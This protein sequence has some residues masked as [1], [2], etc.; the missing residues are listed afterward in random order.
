MYEEIKTRRSF[1][2]ISHPDAGKTTIT[3]KLLYNGGVIQ[4]AGE[5]KARKS[6]RH[7]TS[8]W[9]ELEKQRGISVTTSVMQIPYREHFINLLDTPGHADFSEDTYRTLS[10]VDSALMVIDAAK[11]VEARTIKLMEVCRLRNTPIIT[12]I[13]KLDR[14]CLDGMTLLSEIESVLKI[15]CAPI[16]WPI[17][18][19]KHF[20]GSYNLVDNSV[21]LYNKGKPSIKVSSLDSPE[22]AIIDDQ[23]REQLLEEV[24]LVKEAGTPFSK[25]DYLNAKQTPVFFGTALNNFG[26]TEILDALVD[27]APAPQQRATLSRDVQPDEE[28]FSGFV[29]KIQ[30]NM[31]PKHHDRIAF[32]RITSGKYT[33]GIRLKQVRTGKTISINDAVTFI[34]GSR[35]NTAQ[36][37]AGDI[38]GLHNHGTIRI[39]DTFT[40]GEDLTFTG[41]PNFA[42]ELFRE[43]ILDD[44]LKQKALLK[45]L[46]QL[47]EEGATQYFKPVFGNRLILGAIGVLQFDVVA[48]RLA[49]EYKVKCHYDSA[50]VN[51]ARWIICDDKKELQSFTSQESRYL[52]TD[53]EGKL[54]Y[55]A[56]S[57]YNLELTRERWSK[58]KFVD[59]LD[60]A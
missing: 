23:T 36:A 24:E 8:D 14:D 52:A 49:N 32:M 18:M 11:G 60:R 6:S 58:I 44:P 17:G 7:A 46:Q 54:V 22:C 16:T 4:I 48:H 26:I 38:I 59:I 34:A 55:L 28:K 9:M 35:E 20:Y 39:G 43:V 33:K 10:A 12:F 57:K 15:D 13:N 1:A 47:S 19:G 53:A 45:G 31:D 50:P 21:I 2:I 27:Y 25:E 3:E 5:V 56:P 51:L 41:I 37:F 29:F 42:P 30:A 40:Q